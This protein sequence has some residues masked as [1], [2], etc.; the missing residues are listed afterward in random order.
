MFYRHELQGGQVQRALH[1]GR[2]SRANHIQHDEVCPHIALVVLLAVFPA[3][4]PIRTSPAGCLQ[5]IH[6]QRPRPPSTTVLPAVPIAVLL[7]V[8]LPHC[9]ERVGDNHARAGAAAAPAADPLMVTAAVR[10]GG[11]G[12]NP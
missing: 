7:A 10:K 4:P 11:G 12:G 3:F 9:D 6:N 5:K 8:L 1:R 2:G